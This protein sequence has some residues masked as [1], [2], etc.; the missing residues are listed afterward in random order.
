MAAPSPPAEPALPRLRGGLGGSHTVVTY[1][2]LDVLDPLE[3]AEPFTLDPVDGVHLYFHVAFCEFICMFCHYQRVLTGI[4]KENGGVPTYVDAILAEIEL[5][6]PGLA[7]STIQSV[8]LG[9]GT[10][11]S[12]SLCQLERLVEGIDGLVDLK[13]NWFCFETSPIA[14]V[15]G[16]GAAKIAMLAARGADRVS[17]GVQSFDNSILF[18]QRG[19]SAEV[20]DEALAILRPYGFVLNIDLIQDLPFQTEASIDGDLAAIATHRP[21]QVTW[22]TLRA[23]RGS[24]LAKVQGSHSS[25]D[26]HLLSGIA[27]GSDSVRR[28]LQIIDGMEALGYETRPGGRFALPDQ[29]RDLYKSVRQGLESALLGF[30]VSAYSHGWGHIFRNISGHND[31]K[32]IRR[33][34]ETVMAGRS[35][36]ATCM[37][38]NELEQTAAAVVTGIRD[39]LPAAYLDRDDPTG[40]AWRQSASWCV[41][42]GL[43]ELQDGVYRLTRTGRALEEEIAFMF[44][45]VPVREALARKTD[46]GADRKGRRQEFGAGELRQKEGST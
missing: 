44:Y 17:L 33:Y 20:V 1:P 23:Q 46:S 35:P 16:G 31:L 36:I 5:R 42:E 11:T 2:P 34:V 29:R 38:V 25:Q 6:R 21:E 39:R 22:Y 27:S 19:H 8:Y 4:E 14:T 24:S 3:G 9:G 10:P 32:A 7:G 12:L 37:A 28:R 26:H 43:I 45:S 18:S 41:A 30:G 13:P 15:K 40:S